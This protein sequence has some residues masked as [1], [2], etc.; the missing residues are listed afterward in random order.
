MS[1]SAPLL[2]WNAYCHTETFSY[3]FHD[4]LFKLVEFLFYE[5]DTRTSSSVLVVL[6]SN[7]LTLASAR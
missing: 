4:P 7:L 6:Q 5:I 1:Q 2:Q 3:W